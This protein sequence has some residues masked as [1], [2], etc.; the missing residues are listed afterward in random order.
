[1][2]AQVE[3]YVRIPVASLASTRFDEEVEDVGDDGR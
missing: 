2:L 3:S 1:M